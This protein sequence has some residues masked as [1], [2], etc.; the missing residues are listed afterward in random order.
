MA[1]R[2][3]IKIFLRKFSPVHPVVLYATTAPMFTNP[4]PPKDPNNDQKLQFE[5]PSPS[6]LT[7]DFLIKQSTIN[8]VNSASQ[9]LTVTYSAIENTSREYRKLLT[10]LIALMNEA[11]LRDV[12]D[13]HWDE[14]LEIRSQMQKKKHILMQFIGYMDYVHKMAEAASEISFLAGMDNLSTSLTQRID[15]ALVK[16]QTE[17]TNNS[18]LEEEYTRVQEESIKSSNK[19]E[20]YKKE[21]INVQDTQIIDLDNLDDD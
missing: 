1:F 13:S 18:Q 12:T 8:A 2:N 6:N 19:K 15:D 17:K 14:I 9:A 10:R 11:I 20:A 4:D 5:P 16:I 3:M 7:Y 21:K